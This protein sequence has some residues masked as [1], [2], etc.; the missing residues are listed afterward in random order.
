MKKIFFLII[1]IL[2]LHITTSGNFGGWSIS[3]ELFNY[4][5]KNLEP[6]STILELG[7]GWATNELS[8]YYTVYSVEHNQNWIG[9]YQTNYIYAPI[10]NGWY[11][12]E[13]LKRKL[14]K[15]YDLIL[16]D[17]PTGTIGR[18]GFFKNLSL[19][20]TNIPIIFDD[21]NR[22]VE[23]KLMLDIATFLNNN[24]IIF[25]EKGKNFGVVIPKSNIE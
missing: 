9:K 19:F 7:S 12:I 2:S 1:L 25:E 18:Y 17:G 14:P 11:D 3:K 13:V 4:I 16:V 8:K 21:T 10:K 20:K 5:K 22:K 23:Y 24:K 6:G 15:M